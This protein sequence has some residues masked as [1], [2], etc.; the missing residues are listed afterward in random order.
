MNGLNQEVYPAGAFPDLHRFDRGMIQSHRE[1][2]LSCPGNE[3]HR[4]A[5]LFSGHQIMNDGFLESMVQK[6]IKA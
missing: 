5:Y 1:K 6:R 3:W 4:A 2:S